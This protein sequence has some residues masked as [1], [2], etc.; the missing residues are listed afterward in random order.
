MWKGT[1]LPAFGAASPIEESIT[2]FWAR[3]IHDVP[4]RQERGRQLNIGIHRFIIGIQA[5]LRFRARPHL[6]FIYCTI[7]LLIPMIMASDSSGQNAR[8]LTP[9]RIVVGSD[10]AGHDYKEAIKKVLKSHAGV[11]EVLDVGVH[12]TSDST[13]Y[14]HPAVDACKKIKAGEVR[15]TL[16]F[17]ASIAFLA[18][19]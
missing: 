11:A 8:M 19:P 5:D 16:K 18:L 12:D 3:L 6:A 9:I 7:Q 1:R 14:P 2:K 17:S 4:I 13:A 10:N 15:T